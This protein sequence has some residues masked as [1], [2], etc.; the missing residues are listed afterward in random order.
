MEKT[1]SPVHM[2]MMKGLKQTIDPKNV[3]GANNT[4]YA[5]EQERL[6]DLEQKV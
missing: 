1:V 4:I 5:T 3:F 6:D 2:K